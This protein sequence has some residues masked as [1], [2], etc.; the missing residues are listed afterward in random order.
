MARDSALDVSMG[1]LVGGGDGCGIL[2]SCTA[3]LA[4]KAVQ[5]LPLNVALCFLLGA[6][7]T[8]ARSYFSALPRSA[9]C[10]RLSLLHLRS[11]Q[12]ALHARG[13]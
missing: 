9:A 4:V 1:L 11:W 13:L 6:Q 5:F 12:A 3:S 2:V 10:Q 8:L 7:L